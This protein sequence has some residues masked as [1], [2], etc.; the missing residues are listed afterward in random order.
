MYPVSL[1]LPLVICIYDSE[2]AAA[3]ESKSGRKPSLYLSI[4]KSILAFALSLAGLIYI[5][6]SLTNG[7]DF[8]NRTYGFM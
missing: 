6:A 7:T 8:I 2:V 1:L 4:G 3:A 5:S